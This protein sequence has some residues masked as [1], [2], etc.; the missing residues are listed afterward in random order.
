MRAAIGGA[1]KP[2]R[3]ADHRKLIA[4]GLPRE[5]YRGQI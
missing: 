2:D 5:D 4:V 3:G 1:P